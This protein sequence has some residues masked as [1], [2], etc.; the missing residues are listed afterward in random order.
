MFFDSGYQNQSM[1]QSQL[2][3]HRVKSLYLEFRHSPSRDTRAHFDWLVRTYVTQ[4]SYEYFIG[5]L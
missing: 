5:A 3:A 4:V 1:L 2:C